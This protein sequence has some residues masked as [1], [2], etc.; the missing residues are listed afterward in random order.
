[1]PSLRKYRYDAAPGVPTATEVGQ[2]LRSILR[3]EVPAAIEPIVARTGTT[4]TAATSAS[5]WRWSE[6]WPAPFAGV[7]AVRGMPDA[8]RGVRAHRLDEGARGSVGWFEAPSRLE[9]E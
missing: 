2:A 8:T 4:W 6:R 3:D 1:L 7:R 9:A 5:A